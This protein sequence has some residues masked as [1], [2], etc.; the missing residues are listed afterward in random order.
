MAKRVVWLWAAVALLAAPA[1]AVTIPEL[2]A[3]A[4]AGVSD[5][6]LLAVIDRDQTIFA[7][8]PEALAELKREGLSD[9]V[10]LAI[11]RSGR[12]T[13][14]PVAA[15]APD[16]VF[17]APPAAAAPS[18]L[19]VGHGPD[20]PNTPANEPF[21]GQIEPFYP[22]VASVVSPAIAAASESAPFRHA[23]GRAPIRPGHA[24]APP[25]PFDRFTNDPAARFVSDPSRRFLNNG[26]PSTFPD[27]H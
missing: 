10:I 18:V 5:Q 20:R 25:A 8:K 4:K 19:I 27:S 21:V 23:R 12:Q 13:P 22:W 7:V 15:A 2:V 1:S 3:L 11:L 17:A 6:V 9:Q 24:G 14:P 16:A 26:V